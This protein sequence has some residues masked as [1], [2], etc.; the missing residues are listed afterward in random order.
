MVEAGQRIQKLGEGGHGIG[1]L[2]ESFYC[3]SM[4]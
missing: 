3:P 2:H 1:K 4:V